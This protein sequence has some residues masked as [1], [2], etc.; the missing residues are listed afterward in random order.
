MNLVRNDDRCNCVHTSLYIH[1]SFTVPSGTPRGLSATPSDAR[2][3]V[4]TWSPPAEEDKNGVIRGYTV[5]ITEV[6]TG[7]TW[8]LQ[9]GNT[10]LTV[11][12]LH[13][14]YSYRC[15][16][17]ARTAIGVGPYTYIATA[18]LPEAG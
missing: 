10:W 17:A 14:H 9:T 4:L 3:L 8:Q 15:S 11:Q 2:T 18:E 7:R 13:P 5:N 1:C 12:S 6:N 16:V